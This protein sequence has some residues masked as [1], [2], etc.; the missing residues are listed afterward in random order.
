VAKLIR[1]GQIWLD[2]DEIFIRFGQNQN[3]ASPKAFD[4]LRLWVKSTIKLISSKFD[5]NQTNNI[6]IFSFWNFE[7]RHIPLQ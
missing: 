6:D 1:F 3:L 2:L 7:F 5:K 4:L